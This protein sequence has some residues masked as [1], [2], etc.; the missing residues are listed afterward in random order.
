MIY[1][2]SVYVL[3]WSDMF[4][5]IFC[6]TFSTQLLNCFKHMKMPSPSVRYGCFIDVSTRATSRVTWCNNWHA[7]ICLKIFKLQYNRRMSNINP[8]RST[9]WAVVIATWRGLPVAPRGIIWCHR[10]FENKGTSL[11]NHIHVLRALSNDTG[12]CHY[13]ARWFNLRCCI[14]FRF[15]EL[16]RQQWSP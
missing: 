6:L 11:C 3:T 1:A 15:G 5:S 10:H 16:F 14:I 2:T 7:A 9:I 12:L 4:T 8:K 13:G